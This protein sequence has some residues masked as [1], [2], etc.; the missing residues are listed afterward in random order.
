[1]TRAL[2]AELI[3]LRTTRTFVAFVA[4]AVGLS[5]VVVVLF[6]ALADFKQEDVRSA[7]TADF[8]SLFITL[9]GAIG[10]AGEWRHRTIANTVLSS[11]QRLRLLGA[12]LIAYA[13]GG[14]LLSLA[15][16]VAIMAVGTAVLSSRGIDTLSIGD[17][18]DVLWRNLAI[19]AFLGPIGVCV[20]TLIRNP[21]VAIVVILGWGF[22]LENTLGALA[23]NVEKFL[24]TNGAPSGITQV[25]PGFHTLSLGIAL[26]VMAGWV[27]LFFA[28]AAATFTKRDLV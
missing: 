5:L 25:D 19:A 23:P 2:Q 10:M 26:L 11:P 13:V 3:K 1:V 20:G 8:A 18:L 24:P 14:A 6:T 16:N 7:F 12:K 4:S 27:A 28:A 17:L 22:V 9:L 15:V 21:A